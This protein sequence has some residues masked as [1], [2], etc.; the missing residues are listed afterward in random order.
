MWGIFS[1]TEMAKGVDYVAKVARDLI[2]A[3]RE[4]GH[5]EKVSTRVAYRSK[6]TRERKKIF[7]RSN[8]RIFYFRITDGAYEIY[9]N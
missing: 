4:S 3:R 5:A 6:V 1:H 9:E 2:K 7:V 8:F